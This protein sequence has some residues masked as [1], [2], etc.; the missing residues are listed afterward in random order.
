M[1]ECV[2]SSVPIGQWRLA[3]TK[4]ETTTRP[5]DRSSWNPLSILL[6]LLSTSCFSWSAV[7][8]RICTCVACLV[9]KLTVWHF[10]SGGEGR[11]IFWPAEV[12]QPC[13]IFRMIEFCQISDVYFLTISF[14]DFAIQPSLA[15][16]CYYGLWWVVVHSLILIYNH[17]VERDTF[18]FFFRIFMQFQTD[19]QHMWIIPIGRMTCAQMW[20]V[21]TVQRRWI[22]AR[23]RLAA[24]AS[25][26]KL[27][28]R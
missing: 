5:V 2:K 9:F 26:L 27:R 4:K 3:Y 12:H 21:F 23:R 11:M 17:M 14:F 16:V 13:K 20:T 1:S 24:V 8:W 22:Y 19:S 15:A 28:P 7:P 18:F 25:E 6:L 10:Q